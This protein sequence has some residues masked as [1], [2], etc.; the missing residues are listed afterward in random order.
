[1]DLSVATQGHPRPIRLAP[2]SGGS[3]IYCCLA[4]VYNVVGLI[5]SN[6]VSLDPT[7]GVLL[8]PHESKWYN[9][10]YLWKAFPSVFWALQYGGLSSAWR[11]VLDF[12]S[13]VEQFE[14]PERQA[15]DTP[16]SAGQKRTLWTHM[17]NYL[18]L[19][20]GEHP[21]I[22]RLSLLVFVG[23]PCLWVT[24]PRSAIAAGLH[25]TMEN[26]P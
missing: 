4:L 15:I 21:P 8:G 5:G 7:M 20:G 16:K 19:H 22:I 13:T 25:R 6:P 10:L 26:G 9:D 2:D 3:K 17:E 14:A 18:Y 12:S 1:M 24:P 23:S 11:E